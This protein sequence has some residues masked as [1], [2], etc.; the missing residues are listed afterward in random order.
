MNKKRSIK[1]ITISFGILIFLTMVFCVTYREETPYS[2]PKS[3]IIYP[4]AAVTLDR[5]S[6]TSIRL[7]WKEEAKKVKICY[8]ISPSKL[9]EAKSI[10][11]VVTDGE[12]K[13]YIFS[14]LE[15]NERYYFQ[16]VFENDEKEKNIV[17][18]S[19]RILPLSSVTNFRDIGGYVT[20]DGRKVRWGLFYR[21]SSL[22]DLSKEEAQY[23]SNINI[24]SI[25]DLRTVEEKTSDPDIVLENINYYNTPIYGTEDQPGGFTMLLPGVDINQI[26]EQFYKTTL[27]D[28]KAKQ[29]GNLLKNLANKQNVPAIVHCTAGKDRAGIATAL[30][31]IA[32]GIPDE[33]IIADYTI[34]N[35]YF[36]SILHHAQEEFDKHKIIMSILNVQAEDLAPFYLADPQIIISTLSHI[37]E[38]YGSY[39]NYLINAAGLNREMIRELKEVYLD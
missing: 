15:S 1:V 33:T 34:S 9:E 8:S 12:T 26:W 20:K 27:I 17:T 35:K 5:L 37:R 10:C 2:N 36:G 28:N 39:E 25:Y 4:E 32:L 21:S 38:K 13:E 7:R 24:K 29:Y 11:P 31:L 6:R 18:V 16:L 19:E 14:G 23:L 3:L 22:S 30:L